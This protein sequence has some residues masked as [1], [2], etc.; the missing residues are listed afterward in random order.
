MKDKT[1][2]GITSSKIVRV[3]MAMALVLSV[4][5]VPST[6]QAAGPA[7]ESGRGVTFAE[8]LGFDPEAFVANLEA[9]Q[10]KYLGTP[11]TMDDREA[12]PGAGMDCST[13]VSYA[14]INEAG[15]SDSFLRYDMQP[16]HWDDSC[17]PNTETLF[18]W[19]FTNCDVQVFNSKADL[20]ASKPAKG[21]ILFVWA[22]SAGDTPVGGGE[23]HV[24]IYWG[25][26]NGE[27]LMFHAIPPVCKI[28]PIEGKVVG[29]LY[30][31]KVTVSHG[32][33]L[34]VDKSAGDTIVLDTEG[35]GEYAASLEGAQYGVYADE[36][37][38]DKVASITISKSG[39]GYSGTAEGL[40]AGTYWVKETKAPSGYALDPEVKKVVLEDDASIGSVE[41]KQYFPIDI[42]VVK[43]ARD[44][45]PTPEGDASF[46]GA[47]FRIDYPNG[48]SGVYQA[49]SNGK[50]SM[51]VDDGAFVEGDPLDVVDGMYVLQLGT[52]SVT[53][54]EA[55][56]GCVIPDNATQTI[57][58][59]ATSQLTATSAKA[60]FS[61]EFE[62]SLGYVQ[63][64][65]LGG[66]MVAKGDAVLF[67]EADTEGDGAYYNYA[68]GDATLAGAEFTVYNASA[69]RVDVDLNANGVIDEG[70]V[71]AAGE[72]I[73]TI[74]TEYDADLDAYVA[75]TPEDLLPYGTYLVR[76]AKAPEGYTE[77]GAVEK[78]FQVREDGKV[79]EFLYG[80]GELNEVAAGGVQVVK[81]DLELG[82]SEALGGSSHDALDTGSTLSG[83]E[84]TI[85]NASEH[86]VMVGGQ[87]FHVGDE[88]MTIATR[89]N[90]GL[91]A[92]TAETSADALPYGTYTVQETATNGSYLLTDGE[93][94]TFEVRADG[95]VVTLSKDGDVLEFFNQVVRNDIEISKKADDTNAAQQVAFKVTNVS[96]GEAHVVV[97]DRNGDFSSSS[98]WNKHSEN[99]NGN[100]H[101]LEAD[102]ITSDMMDAKAG[103]WFSTG[104]DGAEAQVDDDLAAFP[105]GEYTIEELRSDTNEGYQLISRTF[106]IDRD[107]SV[108]KAVWMSLD[109]QPGA[110]IGTMATDKSDGDKFVWGSDVVIADEVF[111][112]GLT[113]GDTYTLV[114]TLMDSETGEAVKKGPGP[115]AEDVTGTATF[116]AERP[117]GSQVV[118]L[119]LDASD[120][121]GKRLVVF[122]KLL[123]SD[124][125]VVATHEDIDDAG[126]SVTVVEIGTTLVDSTDGDH[127]V[128][129]GTVKV[130][131]TVEYKGLT[132]GE[133]YTAHGT[134]MDKSTGM[135]LEDADGNPVTASAEFVA[136]GSEGSVEVVFEFDASQLE[137]GAALVAFEEVLDVDGNVVA[138]HQDLEDEGQTVVVDNPETP[139][140]P[141]APSA[142]Y[143][144]TGSDLLPVWVLVCALVVF[145][146]AAGAYALR[147]RARHDSEDAKAEPSQA[148]EE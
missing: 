71:F 84:F 82:A 35:N 49:D 31:A 28:G 53:E 58:V 100:D 126:Q 67:D 50:V 104:E 114:A 61:N 46:A 38:T 62:G 3:V 16:R 21:D 142:P 43:L 25:E 99:T 105:Y 107:S 92:Y 111:H 124:G 119:S 9:H 137:E 70:E 116:T 87:W 47:K 133:A 128:E 146:G 74:A 97:T 11:Y 89:W 108:A 34:T 56:E 138:V 120:L 144:K 10:N 98:S 36:A 5:I 129:N 79:Y 109:D 19:A 29:D 118:E 125:Q 60:T 80:D 147:G 95:E 72:A 51:K 132:E 63:T 54:V 139:D 52:Y 135:P 121:A 8:K 7:Y 44:G 57:E 78:E 140:A 113:P 88:V 122:E 41:E 145:G 48:K 85:A 69:E 2:K 39:S 15:V 76:E 110:D 143:D 90:E 65:A 20:L 130:V 112:D 127:I 26:G 18:N 96:T 81:S 117:I 73:V 40:D 42:S 94:R 93:P 86:G 141:E 45:K 4:A 134:I 14:L 77:D 101:L 64:P 32:F 17:L 106:W 27:D 12:G 123:D 30:Y 102:Y 33:D 24:G 55:P 136:E 148:E 131:D 1:V 103:I 22:K 68:Q 115:L 66:V 59:T 6:A 91:Q 75:K 83:I 37:C 13:F 23:S